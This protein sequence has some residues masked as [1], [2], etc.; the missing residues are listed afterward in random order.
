MYYRYFN[1]NLL[2]YGQQLGAFYLENH[3]FL[4]WNRGTIG[5]TSSVL[6]VWIGERHLAFREFSCLVWFKKYLMHF[7]YLSSAKI[8]WALYYNSSMTVYLQR[9]SV[10]QEENDYDGLLTKSSALELSF[11][12]PTIFCFYSGNVPCPSHT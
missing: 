8:L 7:F 2:K 10:G 3:H 1:I 4:F 6:S 11:L 9:S 12:Y 5:I